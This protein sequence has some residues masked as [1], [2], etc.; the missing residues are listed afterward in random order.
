MEAAVTS[1]EHDHQPTRTCAGCREASAKG[2][3]VRV[4]LGEDQR[5]VVD[6]GGG[7]FGRGAWLHA[8]RECI[9]R[10]APRGLSKSF[11]SSVE[12]S[13]E[14][15]CAAIAEAA[16]RKLSGLLAG[17]R[18]SRLLAIG[19]N[20]TDDA[21]E[22]GRAR[23]VIVASDAKAAA[24]TSPVQRM[25]AAGNAVAWGDKQS[26]GAA[27]GRGETGVVAVLD[28]GIADALRRAI[29]LS[30]V[31]DSFRAGSSGGPGGKPKNPSKRRSFSEK[32]G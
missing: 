17:A 20:A 25:V 31:N 11:K 7:A 30:H 2:E 16:L 26:L 4:V 8:R 14:Q 1:H 24:V 32:E 28:R 6:L 12:T 29:A 9:E 23:L 3:L 15:L 18:G 21:I 27:L 19:T 10:A 5:V 22:A 13:A